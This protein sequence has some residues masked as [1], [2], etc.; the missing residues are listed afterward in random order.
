M[1][2]YIYKGKND[3]SVS[4]KCLQ[5]I[6]ELQD[7]RTDFAPTLT[8]HR[9]ENTV[10]QHVWLQKG[11]Q[12]NRKE[13]RFNRTNVNNWYNEWKI[14]WSKH[15]VPRP[16]NLI[17]TYLPPKRMRERQNLETAKVWL[18]RELKIR[19]AH[20]LVNG[21]DILPKEIEPSER[22]TK[23]IGK[24]D[25]SEGVGRTIETIMQ[26][27]N[28]EIKDA[29]MISSDEEVQD[30]EEDMNNVYSDNDYRNNDIASNNDNNNNNNSSYDW[31]VRRTQNTQPYASTDLTS[32]E[33]RSL[34]AK[35]R[36]KIPTTITATMKEEGY[37]YDSEGNVVAPLKKKTTLNE[38]KEI[39]KQRRGAHADGS[40]AIDGNIIFSFA[41]NKDLAKFVCEW[42]DISYDETEAGKMDDRP[43]AS[44]DKVQA[45]IKT[46]QQDLKGHEI[47]ERRQEWSCWFIGIEH[48]TSR[49][50]KQGTS[51]DRIIYAIGETL[52]KNDCMINL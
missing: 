20:G 40:L 4:W 49:Y 35:Q 24:G 26:A 8:H 47:P 5:F 12:E 37:T 18:G 29:M 21:S 41:Q 22:P 42:G 17:Y 45:L 1:V 39:L 15:H 32:D 36:P 52:R 51:D 34:N 10:F 50:M 6:T 43:I 13:L 48:V 16:K 33:V 9:L 27:N 7:N 25:P 44:P 23:I 46:I 28:T 30:K 3:P 38:R 14:E 11:V 19:T 31:G 2:A